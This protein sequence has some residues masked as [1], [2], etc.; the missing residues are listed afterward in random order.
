MVADKL[1]K[2]GLEARQGG[3]TGS[4]GGAGSAL[5]PGGAIAMSLATGDLDLTA[6]GT[7]TFRRGDRIVAFGHPFLG[8][9]ALEAPM[10]SA[11]IHDIEPS[12]NISSKIGSPVTQVGAFLQDRPFSV[13]GRIGAKPFMIPV[14]VRVN[15]RAQNRK[16]TFRAQIVRHQELTGQLLDIAANA[17]VSQIHGQPGDATA[18]VTFTLTADEVGTIRRSNR[19]FSAFDI[20]GAATSDLL[21]IVNTLGSNNL[22][23]VLIRGVTMDV[24]IENGRKTAQIERV[25][26]RQTKYEPGTR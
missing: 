15:D 20:G 26:L 7:L 22:Y 17:A 16:R 12:Y 4:V 8:I 13:A 3:G 10:S 11:V 6:I 24:N 23:P 25:F 18:N 2:L 9:G 21:S 19:V 5:V 1:A 14:V